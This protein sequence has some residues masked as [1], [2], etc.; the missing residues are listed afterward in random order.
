RR[1]RRRAG[2]IIALYC[3]VGWLLWLAVARHFHVVANG[4]RALELVF[5]HEFS[6]PP[7]RSLCGSAECIG[8][9][10]LSTRDEAVWKNAGA[11]WKARSRVSYADE[12]L[13][14]RISPNGT[15]PISRP[16]ASR[17]TGWTRRSRQ[18]LSS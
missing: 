1:Q 6:F 16:R 17:G 5:G 18:V 8:C 13:M 2:G 11:A 15:A 7:Q 12:A 3:L 14:K 10:D 4:Q 9:A